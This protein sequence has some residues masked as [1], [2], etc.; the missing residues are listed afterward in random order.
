MTRGTTLYF[1][2]GTSDKVYHAS[3]CPHPGTN[4]FDVNFAYGR[5]GSTMTTGRKNSIPV[6]WEQASSIYERLVGEK[7]GKG[8]VAGE[9]NA[10]Y[11]VAEAPR[12]ASGITP[13]LLNPINEEAAFALIY[14]DEYCGQEKLDGKH[15][16][17]LKAA[18][19]KAINKL[20]QFVGFPETVLEDANRVD[21]SF[22]VD[23]EAI[24]EIL[25]VF[26]ILETEAYGN[27]RERTY[28]ERLDILHELLNYGGP[29]RYLRVVPTAWTT[30]AKLAMWNRLR[31]EGREGMVFKRK[32]A[33]SSQG[34]PNSG[35]DQRKCKFYATLSCRVKGHNEARSIE[36]ELLGGG[37]GNTR[38]RW[39]TAGN[40]TI[41]PNKLIP[42]V[43]AIV[44]VRYLYALPSTG[45]LYQSTYLGVRDDVEEYDCTKAQ[46]KYK[47]DE[48]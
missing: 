43:G 47:P 24:G 7:I 36:V 12:Q 46:L 8:Y 30:A 21:G 3:I 33:K 41:P 38:R 27:L 19:V 44:E 13:Q 16:M 9:S 14:D 5:R 26:D 15:L 48:E 10:N 25:H 11:V 45:I 39:V 42:H 22:L 37:S 1:R 4:Y 35:G 6:S 32:K 23:A 31:E 40:V 29:F 2:N 20:G 28:E 17:L 18:E 34:R